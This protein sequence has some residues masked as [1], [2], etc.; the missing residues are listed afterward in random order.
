M[1]D[2]LSPEL[3]PQLAVELGLN[4]DEYEIDAEVVKAER[5]WVNWKELKY[6]APSMAR[7]TIFGFLVDVLIWIGVVLGPFILIGLAVWM[8]IRHYR[9][10]HVSKM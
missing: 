4:L 3:A 10:R 8:S 7:G 9:S 6:S 1:I 2:D 5:V